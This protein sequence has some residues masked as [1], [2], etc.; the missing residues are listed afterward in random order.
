MS[1]HSDSNYGIAD[2]RESIERNEVL[3]EKQSKQAKGIDDEEE[4]EES[5]RKKRAVEAVAGESNNWE[6]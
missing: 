6:E 3:T 2:R 4:V 1:A 5:G